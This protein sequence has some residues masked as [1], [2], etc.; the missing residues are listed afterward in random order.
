[1]TFRVTCLLYLILVFNF[2]TGCNTEKQNEDEKVSELK[3]EKD[4]KDKLPVLVAEFDGIQVTGVSVSSNGRVFANFPRWR[5]D[6]NMSVA[7][8]DEAT[9]SHSPYPNKVWNSWKSG[10]PISDSTFVAVQSVLVKDNK[11]FVL[12][13]RNPFFQGL[14]G[15]PKL[16]VFNLD[17]D[18]LER[19][20]SFPEGTVKPNSYVNDLRIDRKRNKIYLTDSNEPGLIIL[21][22]ES[23]ESFRV[24]DNH[25]STRAETDYLKID[26]ITWKGTVHSDGIALNPK[27]DELYY[28]A[29]S[30][31]T[32]YSISVDSL[33]Q[34]SNTI[35]NAVNRIAR[36]SAPDGMIFDSKGN[37]YYA[38][39]EKHRIMFMTPDKSQHILVD[40]INVSWADTF[41]IYNGFL[42]YTNSK[43]HLAGADVNNMVFS[44]YKISIDHL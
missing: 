32:L 16:F 36:T 38:D 28:H 19:V 30:G 1:M 26:T 27:T 44:I 11:L 10:S 33:I 8:V 42:Y 4:S 29:L 21:D 41:S 39:L 35:E 20:Y 43:I 18:K 31:Y 5:P 14:I 6:I 22:M 9:G 7:E 17:D 37:L 12:D 24:L 40:N 13:T 25:Y 23:G 34:G 3:S 2:L 15:Q